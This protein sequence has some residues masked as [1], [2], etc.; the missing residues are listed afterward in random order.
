MI[1]ES[2][3][4]NPLK[5][6]VTPQY[7][8]SAASKEIQQLIAKLQLGDCI[9]GTLIEKENSIVLKLSNGI[10]FPIQLANPV[11]IGKLINFMVVGKEGQQLILQPKENEMGSQ[12]QLIDKIIGEFQLPNQ[13]EMKT[14]IGQF[15]EKQLPLDKE[16]LLTIFR[17]HQIYDLP[18]E[19]LV[20]LKE[21]QSPLIPK[22][23]QEL[24]YLK[25]DVIKNM[26]SDF[27][28]IVSSVQEANELEEIVY[29]L[30]NTLSTEQ[31]QK[32]IKASL[33]G[34]ELRE[35][36]NLLPT[37]ENLSTGSV[38][39]M[40]TIERV[41]ESWMTQVYDKGKLEE[42]LIHDLEVP[43]VL[44]E[45]IIKSLTEYVLKEYVR[46]DLENLKND[47]SESEKI[48]ETSARIEVIIKHLEKM[49]LSEENKEKLQQLNQS[50]QVIQKYNLEAQYFCFPIVIKQQ[51]N[52]GELYFFKP[53]KKQ[54]TLNDRMY[55]V[56]A[57]NMP[58][59]RRIEIHIEQMKENIN[60][61]LKVEREEMKQQIET[62]LGQLSEELLH[63]GYKLSQMQVKLL[64]EPKNELENYKGFYHMD[65]KA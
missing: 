20:N 35:V 6:E 21:G 3:K 2:F 64:K 54:N 37:G 11:E 9:E 50:V 60:L 59:L 34:Q 52:I 57:L 61:T 17:G 40:P 13:V 27:S 41:L 15:L 32:T 36:V 23:M 48:T 18:T 39:Q 22:E 8:L 51:E 55:I 19:V 14:I 1:H 38:L 65:L 28:G 25:A 26:V 29:G 42:L 62:A 7:E 4:F 10:S 47:V 33:Q 12:S 63:L 53:K 49:S 44:Y 16:S 30:G 5:N 58:T 46:M 56:M 43:K 31:L 45:K 24:A